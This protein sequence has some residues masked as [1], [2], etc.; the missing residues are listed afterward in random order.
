MS[1]FTKLPKRMRTLRLRYN[2]WRRGRQTLPPYVRLSLSGEVVQFPHPSPFERIPFVDRL[3][4]PIPDSPWSVSELR[5]VFERLSLDPRIK[6]LVLEMGPS[7]DPSIFQSLYKLILDFRATG[8]R[9]VAYAESFGPFQYYLACACDEIIMPPSAEWMVLGFQNEYV[10]L[11]DALDEIGVGFDVVRVS[12]FKS[13]GDQFVRNDF[14]EDARAQAEWLL[15]ARYA[16]LLRGIAE[17]R[18]MSVARAGELIDQAPFNAC[19]AVTQGLIDAALY[20]DELERYLVPTSAEDSLAIHNHNNSWRER[21]LQRFMARLPSQV[22]S[23]LKEYLDEDEHAGVGLY[24]EVK[25]ALL[26]PDF[27]Y[28]EKLIGVI[29]IEGTIMPG[30]SFN[31]PLPIPMLGERMA[32]S[33]TIAQIIRRAEKDDNLAA[34]ILYVDSPGGSALASDLIAREVR[35]LK[36]KK[37]IVA[38]MDG[39]AASGGYYVAALANCIVAQPLTITGSIGVVSL[40]PNTQ[41]TFDKL[42]LHRVLLQRG[43]RAGLLSDATPLSDDQRQALE[44]TIAHTYGEFKNIVAEGRKLPVDTL[45]PLC[46]GR[47]WTGEMAKERQLVDMLGDMT[48][49][50]DKA[51]ELAHMTSEKRVRVVILTPPRKFILPLAFVSN[52]AG[53]LLEGWHRLRELLVSQRTWAVA[54]WLPT[55]RR[56]R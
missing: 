50:L 43:E 21:L 32:G 11:K 2:N 7:A 4:L 52:P 22:Q 54:E 51:R 20:E 40:K 14:S 19:E 18:G 5:R 48:V 53:A 46:G 30:N 41:G 39:V 44:R 55:N 35:R 45:E 8:K 42:K 17:G 3:H 1:V 29:K 6:G 38:Y 15:D 31:S 47:V 56:T 24:D 12:P 37:P 9:V 27:D 49:A 36:A 34:I 28:E 23:Q 25:D 13:A 26:I 33:G 10:F 16:E